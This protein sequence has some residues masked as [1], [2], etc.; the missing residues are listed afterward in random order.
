MTKLSLNQK[1]QIEVI[2]NLTEGLIKDLSVDDL[3]FIMDKLNSKLT[4]LKNKYTNKEKINLVDRYYKDKLYQLLEDTNDDKAELYNLLLLHMKY[5][6]R[7]ELVEILSIIDTLIG[8]DYLDFFA[9]M[10]MV[11]VLNETNNIIDTFGEIYNRTFI[12]FIRMIYKT[13]MTARKFCSYYDFDFRDFYY[14]Y[15]MI[16]NIKDGDPSPFDKVIE[17]LDSNVISM[18]DMKFIMERIDPTVTYDNLY[19]IINTKNY[20][21]EVIPNFRQNVNYINIRPYNYKEHY[22]QLQIDQ[23]E[24][25]F[26]LGLDVSEFYNHLQWYQMVALRNILLLIEPNYSIESNSTFSILFKNIYNFKSFK[27]VIDNQNLNNLLK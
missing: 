14:D 24:L 1:Q 20:P 9:I 18:N 8:K 2:S 21:L 3:E 5:Y 22:T 23:I 15:R 10:E 26:Q 27:D 25:C 13:N 17:L 11:N 12:S 16:N 6:R 19:L 4:Y 7:E